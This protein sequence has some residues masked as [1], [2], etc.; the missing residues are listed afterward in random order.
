MELPISFFNPNNASNANLEKRINQLFKSEV[1]EITVRELIPLTHQMR[2]K[3]S[4]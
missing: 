3:S 1:P 2:L 4:R